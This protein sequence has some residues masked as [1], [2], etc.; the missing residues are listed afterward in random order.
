MEQQAAKGDAFIAAMRRLFGVPALAG[1]VVALAMTFAG[2]VGFDIP[3]HALVWLAALTK[4]ELLVALV[5]VLVVFRRGV[6]FRVPREVIA[7]AL[8]VSLVMVLAVAMPGRL[9]DGRPSFDGASYVV[10][11][12]HGAVV[13]GLSADQYWSARRA[14]D[15]VEC[16]AMA[17][18]LYLAT[19]TFFV[20]PATWS[21]ARARRPFDW[22]GA[23]DNIRGAERQP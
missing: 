13:R 17:I 11:D 21:P 12:E 16:A 14:Q 2:L 23:T 15:R 7:G 6:H 10:R 3:S 19:L 1:L 8:A 22:V 18:F 9:P 5:V 4:V 20:S